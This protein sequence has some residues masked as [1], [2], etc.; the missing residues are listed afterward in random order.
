M[1]NWAKIYE[2]GQEVSGP[3]VTT[4]YVS[5]TKKNKKLSSQD[6]AEEIKALAFA[7]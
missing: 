2:K 4:T 3:S 5:E 7:I 6:L 1:G